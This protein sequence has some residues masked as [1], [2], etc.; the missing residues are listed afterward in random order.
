V[1][2][3]PDRATAP[4]LRPV[5]RF[6]RLR[7]GADQLHIAREWTSINAF[8]S[9]RSAASARFRQQ[10]FWLMYIV[11]PGHYMQ[12]CNS[13]SVMS[14]GRRGADASSG[15]ANHR[16]G[17][18]ELDLMTDHPGGDEVN[19]PPQGADKTSP[20]KLIVVI[21]N[22][23]LVREATAGLLR[24]WGY[25]VVAAKS[26]G[27]ALGSLANRLPDLIISDYTANGTT[28]S[29]NIEQLRRSFRVPLLLISGEMVAE[30]VSERHANRHQVLCKPVAPAALRRAIEQ[31]LGS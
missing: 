20:G 27:A 5:S 1:V 2:L 3:Y 13:A 25:R 24:S 29:E 12:R 6:S 9:P 23:K 14:I 11:N 16:M 8:S 31:L 15:K 10:Y 28:V 18:L 26:R 19:R 4:I 17:S 22:N 7:V 21:E 30:P